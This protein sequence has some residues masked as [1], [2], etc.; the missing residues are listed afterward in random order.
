[1]TKEECKKNLIRYFNS[2]REK[3]RRKSAMMFCDDIIC[4]ECM[5]REL[6]RDFGKPGMQPHYMFKISFE[7][8]ELLEKWAKEHPQITNKDKIEQVFGVK[9]NPKHGCP[10]VVGRCD[11]LDCNECKEWWNEEYKAPN[12]EDGEATE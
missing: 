3:N 12:V 8:V 9:V 2:L 10:P 7:V 4:S 5:F 1:M 11:D 6:C